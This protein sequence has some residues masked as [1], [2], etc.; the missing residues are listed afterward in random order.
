M[1]RVLCPALLLGALSLG[2]AAPTGAAPYYPYTPGTRWTYT[3]GE[4]QLVGPAVVHRGVRVVPVSHLYGGR[5]FSQ[6]LLELRPDGSVWLRGVHAGGRLSWYTS[7]LNV[8]PPGP[9]SPGMT[10]QSATG[11][12]TSRSRV[13]GLSPVELGGRTLNALAIRTELTTGGKTS[14]QTAYFV[15]TLGVVRYETAD[16]SRVE[17]RP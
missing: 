3:S 4:T 8:Y 7:P 1:M 12:L 6:D 17:L 16:G 14:T 15:P 9:L 10:W 5:T 13:T 2:H 11:G